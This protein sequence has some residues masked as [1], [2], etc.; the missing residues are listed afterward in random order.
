MCYTYN[1]IYTMEY[2]L[3]SERK[4]ILTYARIQKNFKDNMVGEISQS[5]K[6][7]TYKDFT[8]IRYPE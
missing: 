6:T 3:A 1:V 8:Y 5:Q 2:H 7:N 4:K